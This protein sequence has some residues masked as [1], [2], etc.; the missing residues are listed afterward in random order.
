LLGI[1][2]IRF[3]VYIDVTGIAGGSMKCQCVSTYNDVFNFV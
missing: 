2:G 1:S 3:D